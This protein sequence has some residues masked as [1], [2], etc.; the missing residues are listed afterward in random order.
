MALVGGG[1]GGGGGG[2]LR[3]KYVYSA[4]PGNCS[5]SYISFVYG[6]SLWAELN[7]GENSLHWKA[8]TLPLFSIMTLWAVLLK[9]FFFFFV[10][11]RK[12]GQKKKFRRSFNYLYQ[13]NYIY[14]KIWNY[15]YAWIRLIFYKCC[16]LYFYLLQHNSH[17]TDLFN[18]LALQLFK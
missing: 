15:L 6:R 9:T 18:L 2:G 8:K 4:F 7:G 14:M 11:C 10:K 13:Y 17:Q 16:F 1:G 5:I 12:L 3:E